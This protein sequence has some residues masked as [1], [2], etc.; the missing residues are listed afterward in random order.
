MK[1]EEM[2]RLLPRVFRRTLRPASPLPALLE[3][4]ETRH[5]PSEEA[6]RRLDAALDPRRTPDAFVPLLARWLDLDQLFEQRP[7]AG[8]PSAAA[9]V[10]T[11]LGR[12]RELVA[13]AAHLSQW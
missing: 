4:M 6:L 1:R 3:V 11:G 13:A 5:E 2:E 7:A 10:T 12:L 8:G 9:P